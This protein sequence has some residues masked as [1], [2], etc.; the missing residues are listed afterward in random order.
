MLKKILLTIPCALS[1]TACS[2]MEFAADWADTYLEN[3]ID[4]YFEL[5]KD[6]SRFVDK[7]LKEQIAS[8][9]KERL[10]KLADELN[11]TAEQIKK[12]DKLETS[13]VDEIFLRIQGQIDQT[14]ASVEPV[15]QNFMAQIRPEQIKNFEKEFKK[16]N[17]KIK[18][19]NSSEKKKLE[20]HIEQIEKQIRFWSGSISKNQSKDIKEFCS[21]NPYPI[22]ERLLN[23]EKIS[24]EF[25]DAYPDEKTRKAFIKKLLTDYKSLYLPA[26]AEKTAAYRKNFNNFIAIY[27]NKMTPDEKNKLVDNIKKR[28]Q[29]FQKIAAKTK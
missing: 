24:R 18:N 7:A 14:L 3:E 21:N 1:L 19:K 22:E 2:S 20:N 11:A 4:N 27:I 26:Y 23:R 28:A 17:E 5:N 13:Q 12:T 29:E 9:R 16:Q 25:L 6:Q 15:A 10:P 8:V